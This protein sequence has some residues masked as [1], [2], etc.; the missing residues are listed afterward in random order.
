[1]NTNYRFASAL[2]LIENGLAL[3]KQFL[4]ITP[5]QLNALCTVADYM[6]QVAPQMIREFCEFQFQFPETARFF[7]HYAARHHLSLIDLR[8]RL[9]AAQLEYFLQIFREARA[10][11]RFGHDFM[12]NRLAIGDLYDKLNLPI[13]WHLGSY[14]LYVELLKKYLLRESEFEYEVASEAMAAILTVLLYDMQAVIDSFIVMLL[15]DLCVDTGHIQVA[16]AAHDITD[17]FGEIRAALSQMVSETIPTIRCSERA[18]DDLTTTA[19]LTKHGVLDANTLRH[20]LGAITQ[21]VEPRD[22]HQQQILGQLERQVHQLMR[23][24]HQARRESV[25]DSLTGLYNRRAF[26]ECLQNTLNLNRLFGYPA[27]ML[28]IDIDH[29]KQVNDTYGHAVGDAVLQ[30][31]AQQIVRV[32]KRRSDFVARYGGEEFAV[33]LR[34]TTL[35]AAQRLAQQLVKQIRKH[36][37]PIAGVGTIRVTVSI[38]V[39]E[40]QSHESVDAWFRRT[41]ALLYQAKHAGRNRVAAQSAGRAVGSAT[42]GRRARPKRHLAVSPNGQ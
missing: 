5:A 40:L 14:V 36:P 2:C 34:E 12:K 39:S 19:N 21:T 8:T 22:H 37:I 13:K 7:E 35:S 30:A 16:S 32:C 42:Q 23:E 15:S 24:L 18:S 20:T 26:E 3:R 17:H 38:G 6:E 9:E 11:G 41:D 33:I 31:V 28:L 29:F 25:T 4:T 10:G 27:T 1:M